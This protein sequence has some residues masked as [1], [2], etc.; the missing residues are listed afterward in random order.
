MRHV[1][2][3]FFLAGLHSGVPVPSITYGQAISQLAA[4]GSSWPSAYADN[5]HMIAVQS[6]LKQAGQWVNEK[7][8]IRI[9]YQHIFGEKTR[10]I[11]AV[12]I[13]TDTDNSGKSATAWYGDIWFTEK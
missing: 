3:L 11:D 6:G 10:K 13:M 12:A 5:I 8:N 2:M 4:V 9:D 1:F 7:R